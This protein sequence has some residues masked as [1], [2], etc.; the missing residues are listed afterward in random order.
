MG[1]KR[2]ERGILWSVYRDDEF[3]E[4]AREGDE[5]PDF[6]LRRN[7][8]VNSFGV[9]VTEL[10]QSESLARIGRIPTYGRDLLA[11][12]RHIHKADLRELKV[13][14]AEHRDNL[15]NRKGMVDVFF[16]PKL[17][18]LEYGRRLAERIDDK[19]QKAS[20]YDR[21]LSHINLVI[22]DMT[23]TFRGWGRGDAA[24][25][26]VTS[27]CYDTI[28]RSP[29]RE[30][31]VITTAE[32]NAWVLVPMK[33]HLLLSHAYAFDAVYSPLVD[34]ER[35]EAEWTDAFAQFMCERGFRVYR[36]VGAS[37]EAAIGY[38]NASLGIPLGED[39]A[40]YDHA[41]EPL[42]VGSVAVVCGQ[43]TS[44]ELHA[45]FSTFLAENVFVSGFI[46]NAVATPP[47]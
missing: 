30:I 43:T 26:V 8:G 17:D 4:Q 31:V 18:P 32:E 44:P 34:S 7:G 47:S 45:A 6:V 15:G 35:T 20:G 3:K 5:R 29:F 38:G 25:A 36:H 27:L 16:V 39:L 14:T 9:E 1:D 10:Y 42:P 41:D 19:A 21:T 13:V 2:R 23:G 46:Q 11:G 33:Q 28:A 24:A 40:I 12:G 22:H 37:E